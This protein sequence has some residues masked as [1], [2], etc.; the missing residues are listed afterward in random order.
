VRVLAAPDKFRGSAS[1]T[2]AAHAIAVGAERLGRTCRELPLADGGEGTLEA[3]GGPNRTTAVTGP[4]GAPVE[5]EWRLEGDGAVIEMSRASG[6]SLLGGAE[7]NDPLAATT[8]GTGELI[9]AALDAGAT[10]ILVGV[11]G[12]ATTDGGLG[13]IDALGR[14]PFSERGATVE[15]ACD[16]QALFVDAAR[17]FGP[18]KGASEAD[19]AVLTERLE[20]LADEY[21]RELGADISALPGAG[22]AGGLAG[23]LAALG[24]RLAPGLDLVAAAV[25]LDSALEEAD[26][27]ITGEGLLDQTSFDGKVV[28]G[29]LDRAEAAGTRAAVVVG[30]ARV[31]VPHGVPIVVLVDRFGEERSWQDAPGCIADAS[32]ELLAGLG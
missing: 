24:A 5:A 20:G 11:G 15:I 13:A 2:D 32:E 28:G 29:V 14:R 3:L 16:V 26:V 21:R 17:T 27:V 10:R 4:L 1:A 23:G 31:S 30:E 22:A 12:S 6:L 25:G 19:I 18:Q 8:R 9:A 7:H